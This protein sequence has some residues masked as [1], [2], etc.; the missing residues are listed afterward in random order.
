MLRALC[1]AQA[2]EQADT[3]LKPQP[4]PLGRSADSRETLSSGDPSK[5]RIAL[6]GDDG[7][8]GPYPRSTPPV[9]LLTSATIRAATASISS[10]VSVFSRGC[11][12]T[13]MASDFLLSSMPLPS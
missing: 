2:R 9:F 7:C 3:Q 13:A 1:E 4:P 10:S 5:R 8:C 12:V 6:P 11:R